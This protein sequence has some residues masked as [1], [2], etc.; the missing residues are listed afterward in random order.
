MKIGVDDITMDTLVAFTEL[1]SQQSPRASA[2]SSI[3]M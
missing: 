1:V 3:K 2:F